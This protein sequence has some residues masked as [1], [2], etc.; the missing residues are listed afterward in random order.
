L[1]AINDHGRLKQL[2]HNSCQFIAVLILP[3]AIVIAFFSYEVV[4][5]WTQ[6]PETAEKTRL[7]LSIMIGGTALNGLMNPP[8]ALQLAFGWTRLS[9]FKTLIAAILLVPLIIYLT[10]NYG[11]KGASIVWL[12][13]NVGMVFFEIPMM[14]RRILRKEKWKWYWQDVGIPLVACAF[15][16]GM[17]RL[18]LQEPIPHHLMLPY[19]VVVSGSTLGITAVATPLTRS[20]LYERLSKIKFIFNR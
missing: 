10:F 8:Y 7:I 2:Y 18:F 14:H 6:N 16:A 5:L 11:A 1:V 17:G 9:F 20:W 4:F 19:L 12:V 13:L 15:M 3:A